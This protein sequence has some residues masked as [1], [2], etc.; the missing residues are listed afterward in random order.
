MTVGRLLRFAGFALFLAG[1]AALANVF[2]I[3]LVNGRWPEFLTP[4]RTLF[5]GVAH[6]VGDWAIVVGA[7]IFIGPGLALIAAGEALERARSR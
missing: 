5:G 3:V 4:V 7:W 6:Y 2:L 1:V